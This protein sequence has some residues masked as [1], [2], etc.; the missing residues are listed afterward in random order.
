[1]EQKGNQGINH[2]TSRQTAQFIKGAVEVV[3]LK[4]I[5]DLFLE[6]SAC[7]GFR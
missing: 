1:M 7:V 6:T 5:E 4:K 2:L 3:F